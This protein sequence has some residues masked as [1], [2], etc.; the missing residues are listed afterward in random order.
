MIPNAPRFLLWTL[1]RVSVR[2][3]VAADA[4][5]RPLRVRLL[6]SMKLMWENRLLF[7]ELLKANGPVCNECNGTEE[8]SRH[9]QLASPLSPYRPRSLSERVWMG[10]MFP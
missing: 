4:A 9:S 5:G 7:C 2:A 1:A 6:A 3:S 10:C 8:R